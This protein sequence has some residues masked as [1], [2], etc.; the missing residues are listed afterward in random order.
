MVQTF[1][2]CDTGE[3]YGF[4]NSSQF[5]IGQTVQVQFGAFDEGTTKLN[6]YLT[7]PGG[8]LVKSLVLNAGFG[9]GSSVYRLYNSSSTCELDQ[10]NLTIPNDAGVATNSFDTFQFGIF[11]SSTSLGENGNPLSGFLSW[12]PNFEVWNNATTT[13][14]ASGTTSATSKTSATITSAPNQSTTTTLIPENN[15][16]GGLSLGA[17]A[18]IG[19]GVAVGGVLLAVLIVGVWLWNRKRRNALPRETDAQM[20]SFSKPPGPGGN[21]Q[22]EDLHELP[23]AANQQTDVKGHYQPIPQQP[24]VHEMPSTNQTYEMP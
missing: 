9:R 12:S 23:P 24:V 4:G 21:I 5:N 16:S 1:T 14:P 15:S 8:S 2:N 19:V 18:G 13:A 22:S 10:L 7:R 17:K 11:N 20:E 3:W 6:I